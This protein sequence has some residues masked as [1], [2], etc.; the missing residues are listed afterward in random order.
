[1]HSDV[2]G[3][4]PAISRLSAKTSTSIAIA[5]TAGAVYNTLKQANAMALEK[6]IS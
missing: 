2:D 3:R 1:M 4:S 5:F 6:Q